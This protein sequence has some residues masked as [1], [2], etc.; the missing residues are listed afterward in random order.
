MPEQAILNFLSYDSLNAHLL[1]STE[2]EKEETVGAALTEMLAEKSELNLETFA[3]RKVAYEQT[4]NQLFGAISGLA[5]FIMMFSILSMMNTLITNIVTRKQELAMLESIG[6]SKGQIHRMLLG[7][8]LLL[9]LA[10]V[11]VTMTIGTLCGYVLS[12]MLYNV[13]AFYMAFKFPVFMT[14]IYSVVLV[15]VPLIITLV[16]MHSFSKEAL[17]E[18]LRGMEN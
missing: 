17:V 18:R 13:G 10:T 1:V 11:G 2:A 4:A 7:E 8:S 9:V 14:L 3:D 12:N 16:S 5:I 6:M 15:S